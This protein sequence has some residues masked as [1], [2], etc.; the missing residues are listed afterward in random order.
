M[1]LS[2]IL[3][4]TWKAWMLF[5]TA[6]LLMM[7]CDDDKKD[8]PTGDKPKPA[9]LKASKVT[10]APS[11][12]GTAEALWDACS[13]VKLVAT[14]KQDSTE[15]TLKACHDDTHFY[16]PESKVDRTTSRLNVNS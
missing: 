9:V 14:H 8:Q 4:R 11:I 6:A 5:L 1:A 15:V 12:D 7:G 16:L 2:L 3:N 13:A 10:K